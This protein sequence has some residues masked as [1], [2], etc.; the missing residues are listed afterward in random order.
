MGAA[1]N[2]NPE[3]FTGQAKIVWSL[4]TPK[5]REVLQPGYPAKALRNSL[6]CELRGSKIE[7]NILSEITGLSRQSISTILNREVAPG[8]ATLESLK[9]ELKKIQKAVGR[10]GAHIAHL[11]KLQG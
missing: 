9:Q 4:L 7:V 6:I 3:T 11:E 5:Q 8:K 2:V 1:M 10:L